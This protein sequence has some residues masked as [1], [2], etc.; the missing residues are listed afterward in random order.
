MRI[1]TVFSSLET[2]FARR[3]NAVL[4]VLIA[5]AAALGVAAVTHQAAAITEGEPVYVETGHDIYYGGKAFTNHFQIEGRV[6]YCSNPTAWTPKSGWYQK[7][8]IRFPASNTAYEPWHLRV[9]LWFGYG[10]PGF[11]RSMWPQTDWDGSE[12]TDAEYQAYTHVMIADRMWHDGERALALADEAFKQ[13][14]SPTFLGFYF[15]GDATG[16]PYILSQWEARAN[17]IPGEDEF[18]IYMIETGQNANGGQ[19]GPSQTLV[20]YRYD[21]KVTVELEKGSAKPELTDDNAEY[22]LSGAVYEIYRAADDVL[23]GTVTTDG[24][25]M[26]SI[27]LKRDTDYY[28]LE[29]APPKGFTRNPDHMPFNSGSGTEVALEDEPGTVQI[30]LQKRDSATGAGAQRGT[31]LAGAVYQVTDAVGRVHQITT[32]ADGRARME[33]L[34]LGAIEL[35]EIE[36]PRGYKLD[37]TRY[38]YRVTADQLGDEAVFKLKAT[39]SFAEDVMAFDLD[40]V[41][42]LEQG[43]DGSGLQKPASGVQ[44]QIIANSTNEVVATLTTD[45]A[46]RATSVG[47]WYGLGTRPAGVKGALPYDSKGYTVREVASTTPP[48]FQPAP[49]WQIEPTDMIDGICL[50]YIVDND[51]VGSRIQVVKTDAET[52]LPIA[53]AGFTF[54]VLD[55]NKRPVTQ[56]VWYPVPQEISQFTTD[57][58][59]TVTLPERL[60]PGPYY[61]R[62]VAA[63]PPYLLAGEDVLVHISDSPH[64]HP[65]TVVSFPDNQARGKATLRKSCAHAGDSCPGLA[66]ASFDVVAQHDVVSPDGTVRAVAGEVVAHVQTDDAGVAAVEGLYLGSGEATYAFIETQA[67]AGH[68]IDETPHTFTVSYINADVA[69]VEAE[70]GIKNAPTQVAVD[71]RAAG[72]GKPLAGAVFEIWSTADEIALDAD[73]GK[74]AVAIRAGDA[75]TE[76]VLAREALHATAAASLPAGWSLTATGTNGTF[77]LGADASSLDP[78]PY[79]LSLID[80]SGAPVEV[81]VASDLVADGSDNDA[82]LDVA[83]GSHYQIAW[84]EGFLGLGASLSIDQLDLERERIKL[85]YHEE[86]SVH[87]ASDIPLGTWTVIVDGVE[88]DTVALGD[89]SVR[90]ATVRDAVITWKSHLLLP[91]MT[92]H[93]AKTDDAGRATWLHLEA[94]TYRLEE[95]AA[96]AGYLADPAL[97]T[98]EISE[99]GLTEGEATHVIAVENDFT[100]IEIGKYDAVSEEL[101]PGAEL[102]VVDS[103]GETIASWTTTDETHLLECLAPG[104]YQLVETGSPREHDLADTVTFT[105]AA[106]EEVQHVRMYDEPIEVS[107]CLDKRQE[108]ADPVASYVDADALVADGGANRAE[109]VAGED[110]RY[111]YTVDFQSTATTWVDEFTVTDMLDAGSTGVSVLEA[112]TIPIAA[113]DHDGLMNVWYTTGDAVEEYEGDRANATRSDGHVNPWLDHPATGGRLGDDGRAVGYTGGRLWAAD[114]PVDEAIRLDVTDLGLAEDQLVRG[115]RLEYGRVEAGFTTRPDSWD[116]PD[117]KDEHDDLIAGTAED[118]EAET[119][120]RPL[121][122]HMRASDAYDAGASL[123]NHATLELYRN[124]GNLEEHERLEAVDRDRVTQQPV[125]RIPVLDTLLAGVNGE[126]TVDAGTIELIDTVTI[127]QLE[128]DAKHELVGRL[129]SADDGEA[130]RDAN[131]KEITQTISFLPESTEEQVEMR[132]TWDAD[133]AGSSSVVSFQQLYL[134]EDDGSGGETRTLLA[135]HESLDDPDQTV[136][137]ASVP[138]GMPLSSMGDP[139]A[140]GQLTALAA[141]ALGI[142]GFGW[143]LM[144]RR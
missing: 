68:V 81:S 124:G 125:P 137:I 139:L 132:F 38:A 41:K 92:S 144:R 116:R 93:E 119:D 97:R 4:G 32:D 138:D 33:G 21:P 70:V 15:K 40:L 64:T 12:I 61:L 109:A 20:T 113:G 34:P 69:L 72:I 47:E 9:I 28:A 135:R 75:A 82:V 7:C 128:P 77:L 86:E 60:L 104:T 50:H 2:F 24:D 13:W 42:Y 134:V 36:P 95:T 6:G 49:D 66:G 76:V 102:A 90:F 48:G 18:D 8:S 65:I 25:G 52:G 117:L 111:R 114:V 136:A 74:A 10:G 129:V 73:A 127:T 11:D 100:K 67:P 118:T 88:L 131:G 99:D 101:L 142:A 53:L 14:F 22:A 45:D 56:N 85:A 3:R 30:E 108:V 37:P 130:V 133:A 126:K 46:G 94:G 16:Q 105:V 110:G 122:L 29:V 143:F 107:G 106:T 80:D 120:Y 5:A 62:E 23:M 55:E 57:E 39:G 43:G 27:K 98:F 83:A 1:G 44:F 112:I 123:E 71:K 79:A 19:A 51:F 17:E 84:S 121:I 87:R 35:V 96:P 54:Q 63:A 115:V 91:G 26:A 89:G 141:G 103:A 59:G 78:G 140:A 31:S 58:T